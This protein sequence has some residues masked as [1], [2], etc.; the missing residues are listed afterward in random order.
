[1]RLAKNGD[2]F[3]P[4]REEYTQILFHQ[5]EQGTNGRQLFKYL[6]FT[7]ESDTPSNAKIKLDNIANEIIRLFKAMDVEASILNGEQRLASLYRALNPFES[8]PF[9]FDWETM[10]KG[11][12]TEKDF[13]APTSIVLKRSTFELGNTHGAVAGINI[14]GGEIPDRILD[15][16][17]REENII[18]VNIHAVPYETI[19]AQKFVNAKLTDVQKSQVDMQKKASRGGYDTDILPEKMKNYIT[20]LKQ[21]IADL[22]EKSE[23]L[24]HT[25][26]TIRYYAE[27]P[28]KLKTLQDKLI[29]ITQK[30]GGRL[31]KLDFMQEEALGA[32]LPLGINRIPIERCLTTSAIAGFMPFTTEELFLSPDSTYYGLNSLTKNMIMASRLKLDNPNGIFL[33]IPG[34][35]KSFSAKREIFDVFLRRPDDDIFINDPE[36]EYRPLVEMLHGQVIKISS[37]SGNFINPLDIPTD[38]TLFNEELISDKSNFII[39][40]CSLITG[41]TLQADET[42][43]IDRCLRNV[44]KKFMTSPDR[45]GETMPTL[46]DLQEELRLQASFRQ[47]EGVGKRVADSMEMYV[48]GSHKFFNHRTTVDITN[49]LVC[50]D[51]RDMNDQLRDLAMLVIQNEV[52]TRVS[53][54]RNQAKKT[55]Y[56]CDEF[57]LMLRESH[58]AKYSVEIWKRFRK[59]GGIPTGIT[60]NVKD[61]SNSAQVESILSNSEFVYLLSQSPEDRVILADSKHL[62]PEQQKC[63]TNAPPGHG[64]L[65]YGGKVIPFEDKFPQDTQ[66][67]RIMDTKPQ[68]TDRKQKPD[69]VSVDAN[70]MV[71]V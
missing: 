40:F 10:R 4:V 68:E 29:R 55:W 67:Y 2:E 21:L 52:W 69:D 51:I 28:K 49:R 71:P 16:F 44:Y 18:S 31:I 53:S 11:G 54:N 17:M 45:S 7:V 58:T 32:S 39:S 57:H 23:R 34:K 19:A 65:I 36:G 41:D 33:G 12:F 50:F 3:D 47:S 60:Q 62:S 66:M 30:N 24:F 43:M 22:N 6:T 38:P 13:I 59:W 35:G 25:T 46:S 56:Y 14:I 48:N 20:D 5:L 61:L 9:L 42:S 37:G 8:Q 64:L 63:I 27:T 26:L 1:M 70:Q 15:D